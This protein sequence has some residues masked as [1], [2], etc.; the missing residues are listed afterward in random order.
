MEEDWVGVDFRK[1]LGEEIFRG[2]GG[3]ANH[4]KL[5]FEQA[6]DIAEGLVDVHAREYG[7]LHFRKVAKA[8]DDGIQIGELDLQRC[9][10][11]VEN[12][13]KLFGVELLRALQI[14]DGDL[15]GEQRV[16]QFVGEAAG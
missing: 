14:F 11:F 15:Q 12:F 5:R 7:S 6:D 10:R 13:Q 16:A 1:R 8:P 2:D 9:R 3:L 4:V